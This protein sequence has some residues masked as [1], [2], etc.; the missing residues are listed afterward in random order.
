MRGESDSEQDRQPGWAGQRCSLFCNCGRRDFRVRCR[1]PT[2]MIAAAAVD[3]RTTHFRPRIPRMPWS[4]G[5]HAATQPSLSDICPSKASSI[6]GRD[7]ETL[8]DEMS[9]SMAMVIAIAIVSQIMFVGDNNTPRRYIQIVHSGHL[10]WPP[11]S[12]CLSKTMPQ[13]MQH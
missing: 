2:P 12:R 1:R 7:R 8:P 10:W 4:D 13:A 9:R 6:T 5:R 11:R 3:I